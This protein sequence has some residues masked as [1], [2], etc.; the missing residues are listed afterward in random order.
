MS[1]LDEILEKALLPVNCRKCLG[2][3]SFQTASGA[4][5]ECHWCNGTRVNHT[6]QYQI[7]VYLHG[8]PWQDRISDSHTYEGW[9]KMVLVHRSTR[10]PTFAEWVWATDPAYAKERLAHQLATMVKFFDIETSYMNV[11]VAGS[12][13]LRELRDE[14]RHMPSIPTD[15]VVFREAAFTNTPTDP[16][17]GV[18]IFTDENGRAINNNTDPAMLPRQISAYRPN[19][20]PRVQLRNIRLTADETLVGGPE[21]AIP[22]WEKENNDV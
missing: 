3:G 22:P 20:R 13:V 15:D 6:D 4:F 7:A 8:H 12:S 10:Q 2:R 18:L 1:E 9:R 17:A 16:Y 5:V 11:G 14:I 19:G 21:L